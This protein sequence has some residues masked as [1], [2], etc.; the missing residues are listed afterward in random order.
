MHRTTF[1]IGTKNNLNYLK[2]CIDS[3]FKNTCYK[4]FKILINAEGCEDNT[5]HWLKET[6]E[7]H[8]TVTFW[9]H[10][11]KWDEKYWGIGGSMNF[12]AEQTETENIIFLH[13]DMYC[14]PDFDKYLI[15]NI[16]ENLVISSHRIEP[17]IFNQVDWTEQL[18][19]I[20]NLRPGTMVAEKETFGYLYSDFNETLFN[21][22]ARNFILSNDFTIPRGEGAGGF[23]IKKKTW[24][25]I[26]GN[27]PRFAPASYEDSDLF[28][29][30]QLKGVEFEL[31]SKSLIFHWGARSSHFPTDDF[32][33]S[34][35]KQINAEKENR[36][37]W[38]TKWNKPLQHNEVGFF[39]A[40]GMK[41]IDP[42]TSYK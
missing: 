8:D 20:Y 23:I 3:I 27:D 22:F 1:A 17:D 32:S 30:A 29:R 31:T 38:L 24:D 11:D 18:I 33:K 19:A 10:E 4:D 7:N 9:C 2:L 28:I 16:K 5:N 34:S 15:D 40:D 26:G 42:K 12:L 6:F 35:D 13:S 21:S 37:K 14:G 39:S 36:R 25:L 41:I